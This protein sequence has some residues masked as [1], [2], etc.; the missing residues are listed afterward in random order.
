MDTIA[1]FGYA[2][3]RVCEL[4]E[5]RFDDEELKE[6]LED[7]ELETEGIIIIPQFVGVYQTYEIKPDSDEEGE[8]IEIL[9]KRAGYIYQFLNSMAKM[10]IE[11]TG[12]RERFNPNLIHIGFNPEIYNRGLVRECLGQGSDRISISPYQSIP[13]FNKKSICEKDFFLRRMNELGEPD[14]EKL[15][16]LAEISR[17]SYEVL[18][19]QLLEFGL[20]REEYTFLKL[21][22]KF[23]EPQNKEKKIIEADS[24]IFPF[25]SNLPGEDFFKEK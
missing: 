16:E 21:L 11:L 19:G 25:L 9:K 1:K 15:G 13:N 18:Q 2:F 5:G 20:T 12:K 3:G 14:E 4:K 8:N 23:R 10:A 22:E 6:S 17:A 7:L 24:S